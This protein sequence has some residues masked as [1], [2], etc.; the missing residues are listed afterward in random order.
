MKD[1]NKIKTNFKLI[2]LDMDGT[3][4]N[5][6]G[7]IS[8]ENRQAIEEAQAKGVHVVLSTGRSIMTCREFAESLKLSSY[9]VT[10]NGSE[11]WDCAGNLLERTI[12][13]ASH[14]EMMWELR[15]IHN[16]RFW[17]VTSDKV[18]REEF[19]EDIS[20]HQWLKFGFD[21]DEDEVREAV[22]A[23][24]LKNEELEITN[25]SPTNIEVNAIGI[26]KARALLT[27]CDKLGI[28]M[29]EVIAMGDS[30]N[31]IAMIK[32][33]GCG[34]AMGNAQPIVKETADWITGTNAED[35]VA[36]A[37]RHWVL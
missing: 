18:W 3:L 37:I 11:I 8:K 33:A 1:S 16:A 6:E 26:N 7:K 36:Q 4:L 31:D 29:D 28:S 5:E 9:L 2:A 25:S 30:L 10:V 35:G 19:P 20:S 24:L 17:A 12:L 22:L 14:I 13:D 32:E 15:N 34:V 23:E 27:V 21:F